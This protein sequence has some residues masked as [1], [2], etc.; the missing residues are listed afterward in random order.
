MSRVSE[1]AV[2][3]DEV[4]V[5]FD[6][7]QGVFEADFAGD[8]LHQLDFGT[9]KRAVGAEYVVAA[10][11][12]ADDGGFDVGIAQ[13]DLV[14]ALFE[15][16]FVY[17]AACGGVALRVEVDDEDAFAFGGERLPRG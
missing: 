12:T 9:G 4:V 11:A 16:G 13:Y 15:A 6:G 5:V 17:A 7:L 8:F 1:G 3:K 14:H 10:V 2:D